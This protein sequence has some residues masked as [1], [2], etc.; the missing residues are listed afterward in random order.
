M[1]SPYPEAKSNPLSNAGVRGSSMSEVFV[2]NTPRIW[3]GVMVFN[4]C[5]SIINAAGIAALMIDAQKLN[6][7][8]PDQIR[9]VLSTNTSDMDDPLT[10]AFDKGFD[11]ASGHGLV[12]ADKAVG[13]VKFP[14]SYIRDLKLEAACSPDPSTIRNWTINNP[15]PF[16]VQV[17]WYL[18]GTNQKGTIL[19]EPGQT[20]FSTTAVSFRNFSATNIAII[21]WEDNFGFTRAA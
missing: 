18:T 7:I 10:P 2:D 4:F 20:N 19:A 14:R 15:N 11:F 21:N 12:M 17:Q 9:G 16:E 3:S 5:A 13:A 1:T 6:T 8:T